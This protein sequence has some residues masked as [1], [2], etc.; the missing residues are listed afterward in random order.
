MNDFSGILGLEWRDNWRIENGQ[1]SYVIPFPTVRPVNV[2]FHG[3]RKFDYGHYGIHL[4][5][6]DRLT[7][8]GPSAQVITGH[9]IDCRKG[10]PKVHQRVIAQWHPTS[11]RALY[12]PNGVA[13]AFDGLEGIFTLNDYRLFL[14]DPDKWLS[15]ETNWTMENDVINLPMDV[16]DEG[17][18]TVESNMHEASEVFYH[19]VAQQQRQGIPQIDYEYPFTDDFQT[20]KGET[21]RLMFRRHNENTQY[22]PEW[23]PIE[24]I[25]DAGWSRHL[26]VHSGEHSG[27]VPLLD[28]RPFYIVDHDESSYSHDAYGIHLGQVDHLTF[29]GPSNQEVTLTL[30]D[31]RRHSRIYHRKVEVKFN[32]SPLRYLVIPNGVAHRFQNLEKVYTINRP[33]IYT[34]NES[35][36]EP[37]NDVIDWPADRA[38]FPMFEV[39]TKAASQDFYSRQVQGQR[40][41][42]QSQANQA[43]PIVLLAQDSE[44]NTVR[45]VLRKNLKGEAVS[46]TVSSD[47]NSITHSKLSRPTLHSRGTRQKRRAPQFER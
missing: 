13:H 33:A 36:Y 5:Q 45:V 41:L 35:E 27:F 23:E 1:E 43:T 16:M 8:L 19:L 12:V 40:K 15:G 20:E 26:V 42:M 18:P 11:G 22:T 17:L 21:V 31:C 7:F 14:P 32:P 24:G 3:E 6:S 28:P 9:F 34:D 37:G 2:V 46:K 38:D 44:C 29:L 30:V 10:S 25:D 39:S 47:P 4:G